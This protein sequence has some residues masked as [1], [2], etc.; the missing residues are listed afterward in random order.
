MSAAHK[1]IRLM[2]LGSPPD[3][4][5]SV[6]SH[7]AHTAHDQRILYIIINFFSIVLC[8]FYAKIYRS[9]RSN[10][11]SAPSFLRSSNIDSSIAL[12]E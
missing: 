7:R 5:H 6:L 1:T 12:S 10:I 8:Y 4:I 9:A 3:M 2:L 11:S